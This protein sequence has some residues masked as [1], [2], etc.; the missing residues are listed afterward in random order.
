MKHTSENDDIQQKTQS[1][2]RWNSKYKFSREYDS[3]EMS[4]K[5]FY[6]FFKAQASTYIQKKCL[7]QQVQANEEKIYTFYY[8]ISNCIFE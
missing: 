1:K 6:Y 7:Y 4:I 8:S 5:I 2:V 3:G